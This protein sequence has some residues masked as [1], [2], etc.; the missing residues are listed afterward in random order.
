MKSANLGIPTV[1]L[2]TTWPYPHV[3]GVSSH[4]R[5]LAGNLG[6]ADEEVV[7]FQKITG[8]SGSRLSWVRQRMRMHFRRLLNVETISLHAEALAKLLSNENCDIVHCHDAMATWAAIRARAQFG[9]KY[10][11]VSTVHGPVSR[12]MIEEGYS[13]DSPDVKM[14]RRCEQKAWAECDLMIAVDTT[15]RAICIEQGA[16]ESRIRTIPN[17]VDYKIIQERVLALPLARSESRPWAFVP[18]RLSPK[19]GIEY[20]I[21]AIA[22]M[23]H[24]P[25]LLIAGNGA[26]R[27]RLIDLT[28]EL[29]VSDLVSFLGGLDHE[30]MIPLM[31][32][33]DV[34]L[35]PSVPIHGIVEATSIAAIEA[36]AI[37]KAVVASEIGGLRELIVNGNNGLLVPPASPEE[38]AI[39]MTTL[40]AS[41][42]LRHSIGESART[43]ALEKFSSDLWFLRHIEA[44]SEVMP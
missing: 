5:L 2:V 10:K 11:I 3:G 41:P 14:V 37:G 28:I 25:R 29:G 34:V 19:N 31:A 21:R 9:R 39:A 18:R 24:P 1:R 17:A 27:Q 43:V 22:L 32:A 35:I 44:Y 23:E 4:I 26:E 36:M 7:N 15:Q 42:Q 8:F 16:E 33:A 40:L 12:H 20:A 6:I 38:L 30:I 13:E